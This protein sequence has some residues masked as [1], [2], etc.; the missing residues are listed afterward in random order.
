MGQEL[1]LKLGQKFPGDES[2]QQMLNNY[3]GTKSFLLKY[4]DTGSRAGRRHI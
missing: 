1:G 2:V 4:L 3:K